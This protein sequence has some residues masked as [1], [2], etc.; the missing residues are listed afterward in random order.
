MPLDCALRRAPRFEVA[1]N[2]SLHPAQIHVT[3]GT[4]TNSI[5]IQTRKYTCGPGPCQPAQH[6]L[7]MHART[8]THHKMKR[9]E[10]WVYLCIARQRTGRGGK[11]KYTT[12]ICAGIGYHA[13]QCASTPAARDPDA[14]QAASFQLT[15]FPVKH[16]CTRACQIFARGTRI[17]NSMRHDTHTHAPSSVKARYVM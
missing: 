16:C 3:G 14:P 11:A 4:S 5:Q 17:S 13:L 9:E 6:Q 10:K 12:D 1:P 15:M 8:P 2:A 7:S